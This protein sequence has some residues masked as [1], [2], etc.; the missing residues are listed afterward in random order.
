MELKK[1]GFKLL[2]TADTKITI[3][4]VPMG[5]KFESKAHYMKI[6]DAVM[7]VFAL[8]NKDKIISSSSVASFIYIASKQIHESYGVAVD[9]S[10]T[11]NC[12]SI[13]LDQLYISELVYALRNQ[14]TV[15]RLAS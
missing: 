9:L 10:V 12:E 8:A 1:C 11:S 4:A 7:T 14:E 13:Q 2:I 15:S 5:Y 3:T 6:V